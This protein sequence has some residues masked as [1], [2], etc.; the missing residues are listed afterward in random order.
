MLPYYVI[1]NIEIFR[2]AGRVPVSICHIHGKH[3]DKMEKNNTKR[4]ILFL[5]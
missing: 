3:A 2:Q 4:K 1:V 5:V